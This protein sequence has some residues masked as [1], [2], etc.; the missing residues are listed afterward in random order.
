MRGQVWTDV[1]LLEPNTLSLYLVTSM[2]LLLDYQLPFCKTE[3]M[4]VFL[5]ECVVELSLLPLIPH[6]A[7]VLPLTCGVTCVLAL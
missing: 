7:C 2:S 6:V 1:D 4:A 5:Q 3:S